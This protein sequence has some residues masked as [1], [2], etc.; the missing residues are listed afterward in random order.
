MVPEVPQTDAVHHARAILGL[1][2][3]EI[4]HLGPGASVASE[5]ILRFIYGQGRVFHTMLGH[6]D[7]LFII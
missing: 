5:G 4:R 6:D 7:F 3:G 1:P 2:I